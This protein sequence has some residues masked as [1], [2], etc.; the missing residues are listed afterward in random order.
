MVTSLIQSFP[1]V[2]LAHGDFPVHSA[3]VWALRSAKT[4]VCCDG[5]AETLLKMGIEPTYIVGDLDSTSPE[6]QA[7]FADRLHHITEQESNDLTK[8]VRFCKSRGHDRITILGATGKR[9]DHT[10]GN[11]ALLADYAGEAQVQMITNYGVMNAIEQSTTFES[12]AGQQVS[13]F[14][15]SPHICVTL[16]GLRYPLHS[17]PLTKLWLGTLNEALGSEFTVKFDEGK[18]VV[19]RAF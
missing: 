11:I 19:F 16:S 3:A 9:E 8:A 15:I 6:V 1:T 14:R 13:L 7:R 18:M 5:A 17:D 4:V 10:L 12:V 2:I